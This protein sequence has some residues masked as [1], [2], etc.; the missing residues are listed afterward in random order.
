MMAHVDARIQEAWSHRAQGI[1]MMHN[2]VKPT[3]LPDSA[4]EQWL[5]HED[6]N[7][8]AHPDILMNRMQL[9]GLLIARFRAA[10]Q[11][12]HHQSDK[13]LGDFF[14]TVCKEPAHAIRH[15]HGGRGEDD[16]NSRVARRL[17]LFDGVPVRKMSLRQLRDSVDNLQVEWFRMRIAEG[18]Q[19]RINDAVDALFHRFGTLASQTWTMQGSGDHH[20]PNAQLQVMD[21]PDSIEPTTSPSSSPQGTGVRMTRICVRRFVNAFFAMYRCMQAWSLRQTV[22]DAPTGFDCGIRIH[23]V[24]ASSDDFSKISMH[25]DLMLGAKL[26][27]IHD[28]RGYFNC[29]SQVIYFHDPD[30]QRRPQDKKRISVISSGLVQ[31]D[32]DASVAPASHPQQKHHHHQHQEGNPINA[33]HMVPPLMQLYPEI[34]VRH[35]DDVGDLL[36]RASQGKWTWLF[37]GHTLYLVAPPAPQGAASTHQAKVDATAEPIHSIRNVRFLHHRHV[38]PLLNAYLAEQAPCSPQGNP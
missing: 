5:W 13:C 23:H 35:A 15:G 29:I 12:V 20:A 24:V 14:K 19:P 25:W 10:Y 11:D 16:A 3:F 7:E 26:N 2:P 37:A 34:E 4:W 27:Y 6:P 33:I 36:H 18:M 8:E 32:P 28:F 17:C 21:D 22:P 31:E 1:S 30:Y 38:A 9:L